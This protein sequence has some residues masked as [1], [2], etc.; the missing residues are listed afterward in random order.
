MTRAKLQAFQLVHNHGYEHAI[1]VVKFR[2]ELI[3][4]DIDI[5]SIQ[6]IK[7]LNYINELE[8]EVEKLKEYNLN[9]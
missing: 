1:E 2:R 4:E 9:L 7:S 5:C 6:S 3:S 8:E